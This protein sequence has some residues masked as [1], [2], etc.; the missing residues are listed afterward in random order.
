MAPAKAAQRSKAS[1]LSTLPWR[2]TTA[3]CP[4]NE[5]VTSKPD[6]SLFFRGIAN[7]RFGI[8]IGEG[9]PGPLAT[10]TRSEMAQVR[11]VPGMAEK[12]DVVPSGKSGGGAERL[13][14]WRAAQA[15][16]D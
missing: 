5:V 9:R 12:R 13:T 11:S 1:R 4:S 14:S 7:A 16:L 8:L 6:E 15:V 2:A 3:L 10:T